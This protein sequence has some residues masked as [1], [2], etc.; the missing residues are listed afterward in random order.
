V[1]RFRSLLEK[2]V[3]ALPASGVLV[4]D[5]KTWPSN[6]RL[7]K[8]VDN[9]AT[10]VCKAPTAYKLAG[11]CADWATAQHQKQLPVAAAQLL[12][13]LVGRSR[14]ENTWKIFDAIAEGRP[15]EALLLLDRLFEQDEEPMRILGAF[16]SQLRKLA[17]AGRLA[18]QGLSLGA[19]L[20]QAGVNPYGIG[21]A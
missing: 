18:I 15:A 17:Q 19:A 21:S 11:W 5:V 7:A 8:L 3:A 20:A 14:S 13:D 2:K 12:V 6:T 9:A 10:I 16:G 1:T 4:L